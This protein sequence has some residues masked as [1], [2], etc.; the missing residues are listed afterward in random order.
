M[1]HEIPR[2]LDVCRIVTEHDSDSTAV[3]G[4]DGGVPSQVRTLHLRE[5]QINSH[6]LN[7]NALYTK[8]EASELGQAEKRARARLT[9]L[10]S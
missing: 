6:I 2:P 5:L 9:D 3:V 1:S 4:I 10:L 8:S 7:R